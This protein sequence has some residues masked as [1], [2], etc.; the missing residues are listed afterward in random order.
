MGP[1]RLHGFPVAFYPASSS[2]AKYCWPF[3]LA[4][5]Y[6]SISSAVDVYQRDCGAALEYAVRIRKCGWDPCILVSDG[7]EAWPIS[8]VPFSLKLGMVCVYVARQGCILP[9]HTHCGSAYIPRH[10]PG[11]ASIESGRQMRD[12]ICI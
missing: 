6:I 9:A 1:C 12:F 2:E 11:G 5:H 7:L 3:L 10:L 4:V 8:D